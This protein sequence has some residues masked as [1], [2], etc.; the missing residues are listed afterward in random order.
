MKTRQ[1]R[2]RELQRLPKEALL[3]LYRKLHAVPEGTCLPTGTKLV[4]G[5]LQKE[6]P[7]EPR[8]NAG[9]GQ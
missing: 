9:K 5:I 6:Y 1:E 4:A 2:E 7:E 3:E 8:D